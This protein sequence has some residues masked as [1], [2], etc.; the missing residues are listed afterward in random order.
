[1]KKRIISIKKLGRVSNLIVIFIILFLL[2]LTLLLP[3]EKAPITKGEIEIIAHSQEKN[4]EMIFARGN[5]ELH[6]KNILL[7]ADSI[8]LNTKTK[9]VFAEGNVVIHLPGEVVSMEAINFNLDSSQGSLQRA[10]GIMQP[11]VFYEAES[12]ERKN[13]NLYNFK[14]ARFTSC[15]QPVPRWNF[16]CSKANFKKDDYVEMWNS[17]FSIKKIP[18]FYFPYMRYPLGKEKSTGFLM[19]QLGYSGRK[20]ITYSQSFYWAIKRNMDA[21][22]G[23]DYYSTRGIGGGLEY[24]YL[25]SKANGGNLKLYYFN[26]KDN[27]ELQFPEY[28]YIIRFNHNQSLPMKFTLV[29]DVDYQS[30]YDFLREFDNN[31][32]RAVV[33]NRRSQVYLSRSWSYFNFNARLSRFETYFTQKENGIINKSTPEVTFSSSKIKLFSPLYFSFYSSFKRWEYGWESDYEVQ[34]QKHSESLAFVPVFTIPFTSIPWITLN[35]SLSSNFT[36]Y[37][38][39]YAPNTKTIVDE[40]LLRKNYTVNFEAV[41]PVFYK[42]YF[43]RENKPKLKHIIEPS[44][45]YRY[46]SPVSV[47]DRIITSLYFYRNHY[48]RYGLTNRFLFKKKGMPKEVLS[49]GI[50]QTFYLAPEES[51]LSHYRVN[52]EIPEFSDVSGYIRFYPLSKYSIDF[53]AGFNPYHTTFSSLR[54]GANFGSPGDA[55]F[56]RVNWY[57]S[58][59]PYYETALWNRHQVSFFGGAKIPGLSLEAQTEIDFNIKEREILYSALALVYHYQCIDFKGDLRIFYFREKPEVQ[60]RISLGLGNIGKTTDFL[61]G[62]GF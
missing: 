22:F 29:A 5:V 17:V 18:V 14:N 9:D 11:T 43:D 45:S 27:P 39:S 31:F 59:N 48:L 51:P 15:T 61:G 54:L 13:E 1:M 26:F 2:S 49:L 32:N 46:D 55:L 60:F 6:Y 4:G 52:G 50:S 57:K 41:G 16:S 21:T 19:P 56:A 30:S 40:P 28:A 38:Q 35:S 33:S 12:V 8:Q 25:F 53:S 42:I 34:K 47:S 24:R 44:F 36:Y 62:L 23:L 3:Q 58:I 10:H 37:F 7:L 20:G